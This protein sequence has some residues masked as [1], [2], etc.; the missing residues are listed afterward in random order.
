MRFVSPSNN[1]NE[2]LGVGR[3]LFC[4]TTMRAA[5]IRLSVRRKTLDLCVQ[6]TVDDDG[7]PRNKPRSIA[8]QEGNNV[9]DVFHC[10]GTP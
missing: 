5:P 10:A 4:K 9:G 6:T 3:F 7:L 1:L 8:Q 2:R